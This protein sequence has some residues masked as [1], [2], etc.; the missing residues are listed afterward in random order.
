[1]VLIRML[2]PNPRHY[3]AAPTTCSN[4]EGPVPV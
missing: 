1:M 3:R 2:S 4:D